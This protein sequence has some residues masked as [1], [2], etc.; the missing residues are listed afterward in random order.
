MNFHN[1]VVRLSDLAVHSVPK[2]HKATNNWTDIS[3]IDVPHLFPC[4]GDSAGS[5]KVTTDIGVKEN[6]IML[7]YDFMAVENPHADF[8]INVMGSF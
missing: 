7:C 3:V 6:K 2:L 8:N 5:G 1:G 4:V